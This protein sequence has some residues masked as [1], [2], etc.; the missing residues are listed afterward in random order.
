MSKTAI[1]EITDFFGEGL[2]ETVNAVGDL[3]LGPSLEE[4]DCEDEDDEE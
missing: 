4:D 2:V 3:I 1:E